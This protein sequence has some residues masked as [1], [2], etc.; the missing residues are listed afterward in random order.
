MPPS[1]SKSF[2][3]GKDDKP[4]VSRLYEGA[5]KEQF[6]KVTKLDYSCL[7]WGD[8]EAAQLA[9][10]IASGAASQLDTLA[11]EGNP[12]SGAGLD[13]LAAAV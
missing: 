10:V 7:G 9:G 8:A 12:V 5:F 4:L 6:A 13:A 1:E 2:T 11:F 3:N